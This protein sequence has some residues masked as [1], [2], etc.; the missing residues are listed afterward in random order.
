M[1]IRL[2][3]GPVRPLMRLSVN[4]LNIGYFRG[5]IYRG[6]EEK[7]MEPQGFFEPYLSEFF[8]SIKTVTCIKMQKCKRKKESQNHC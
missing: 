6:L 8:Y 3:P 2:H 4:P 7:S 5:I 1:D